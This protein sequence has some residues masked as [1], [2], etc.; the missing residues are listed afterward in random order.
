MGFSIIDSDKVTFDHSEGRNY[1][2]SHLHNKV[3]SK[4]IEEIKEG[5]YKIASTKPTIIS[6]LN[7]VLK[8]DGS[9]RLIQDCSQPETRSLNDY[10]SKGPCKYQTVQDALSVI[11]PGWYMAKVD[12]KA[13]FR[14][15][16]IR[17]N[18]HH[19][20]GIKWRFRG[21]DT[22]TYMS[23][24]KLP[25]GARLSPSIFNILSAS[26]RRMMLRRGFATFSMLDDFLVV[27]R[28]F[29]ECKRALNA[30]IALL[31]SLGFRI[32][33]TKVV[34]PTTKLVFLGIEIDTV[35]GVL[36]LDPVKNEKFCDLLRITLCKKRLSYKQL[37]KLCGK[38]NWAAQVVPWGQTH[39]GP[40]YQALRK[41]KQTHHKAL[42]ASFRE[43]LIWWYQCL[44]QHN[45][46]RLIWDLRPIVSC[47]SDSSQQAGGAF[48]QGDWIYCNWHNDAPAIA[49]QHINIKELAMIYIAVSH[50]AP[51]YPGHKFI[52]QSDNWASVCMVNKGSS[53][54]PTALKLLRNMA[55]VAMKYNISVVATFLPGQLNI[56]SDSISRFHEKGQIA[57]FIDSLRDWCEHVAYISCPL[58]YCLHYHMSKHSLRHLSLQIMEWIRLYTTW[59]RR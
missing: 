53:R 18:Q 40:L 2:Q 3:E 21:S 10:A 30:L 46:Q 22:Y 41:L 34:D 37:E 16:N 19:L 42:V 9:V 47:S 57:R 15:V 1:V 20:T 45:N 32:N 4:L 28:T 7:A 51:N 6:P 31:R 48:C 59:I 5:N 43:T 35:A 17:D 55:T 13:A 25:Q 14:S 56:L 33:W 29:D 23:D 24:T 12:L 54:H 36:C 49:S 52:V 26:I 58:Y 44:N 8:S 50:W 38:L 39:T 11:Q 27:G